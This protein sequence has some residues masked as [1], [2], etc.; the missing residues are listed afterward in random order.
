VGDLGKDLWGWRQT[1]ESKV[2]GP[3]KE[4]QISDDGRK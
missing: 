2:A 4:V 3:T 1:Q